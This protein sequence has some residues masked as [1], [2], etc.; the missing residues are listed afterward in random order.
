M[1]IIKMVLGEVQ[2]NCYILYKEDTKEGIIID[3]SDNA[4]KI[5]DR[6]SQEGISPKAI[7]LTHGHFD[8][9]MAAPKLVEKYGI[10]VYGYVEEASVV[11]DP[12]L[13]ASYLIN[14]KF[15]ME[16]TDLFYDGD[17]LELAGFSL[18]VIHTPGHTRGSVCFYLEDR[19]VL[20]CG[21]TLFYQ[22]IGRTDLP[23]GNQMQL[24]RSIEEHLLA[25]PD[26]TICYS[27]HGIVTTIGD[28]RMNNPFIRTDAIWD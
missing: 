22:S 14:K 9:I 11:K 7:I 27:G 28:E 10:P 6:L 4:N 23:T 20:F 12:I 13:N 24:L 15:S 16:L 25:L 18:K 3:P 8:H 17:I 21:D 19:D 26:D 5:I 1:K 2:T